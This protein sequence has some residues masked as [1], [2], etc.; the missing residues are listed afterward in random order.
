MRSAIGTAWAVQEGGSGGDRRY[1][2]RQG[3]GLVI[4]P[5]F[6]A[7]RDELGNFFSFICAKNIHFWA[8]PPN[9]DPKFQVNQG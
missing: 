6:S 2:V 8:R 7:A 3:R 1:G 4:Y 5:N 9:F